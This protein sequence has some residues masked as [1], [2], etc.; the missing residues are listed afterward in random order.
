MAAFMG[1]VRADYAKKSNAGAW[2]YLIVD[3]IAANDPALA[4][5][6]LDAMASRRPSEWMSANHLRAWVL[7]STVAAQKP[8]SR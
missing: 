4:Q 6:V 1:R 5:T 8:R 7:P 2:G 3:A